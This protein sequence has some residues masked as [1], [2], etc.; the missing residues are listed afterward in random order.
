[1]LFEFSE[2]VVVDQAF[3]DSVVNDSDASIWIGTVTDPINNHLTLSDAVLDGL[4][5]SE[6]NNTGSSSSRWADFNDGGVAGNVLVIAASIE[7]PTPDDK[8]KIHKVKVQQSAAGCYENHAV[9]TT[10]DG[11]TDNDLSH[12]CNP[13]PDPGIDIEKHTNGAD[14][15]TLGEAPQIAAG[16]AIT[17][18]YIVY[19]HG[20][21]SL[22]PERRG[23]R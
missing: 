21:P 10:V 1:M 12:Y 23:N 19:E 3:L 17:W 16:D 2:T 15:D 5:L 20:Q 9:V 22:C 7:D 11:S 18:T 14:A 13:V 6:V 4:E 8:F